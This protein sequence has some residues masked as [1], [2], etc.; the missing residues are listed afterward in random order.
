MPLL[1][2][3][4]IVVESRSDVVIGQYAARLTSITAHAGDVIISEIMADPVPSVALPEREYIEIYNR[5]IFSFSLNKWK[6]CSGDRCASFP[7]VS[8]RPGEYLILCSHTDTVK[9]SQYGRVVGF[10]SFP[11]LPGETGIVYL[12]DSLGSLIHGLEYSSEWY[13]DKLKESGGWALEIIDTSFPFFNDGNWEA[14]SSRTG[15]TPGAVNSASRY[16]PDLQFHGL[17]NVF[18]DDSVTLNILFSETVIDL[19]ESPDIISVG[20]SSIRT[21]ESSDPLLRNFIIRTNEPFQSGKIY[22][23]RIN[24]N[25]TDFAGNEINRGVFRF[26]IPERADRRDIVFNELLFNPFPD[27]P[28]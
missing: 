20:M 22:S 9:F 5:T 15:G 1:A 21:V 8:I 27:D 16:N 28:D 6:L 23:F 11:S 12:T 3:G 25:L 4:R 7:E 26:G 18:P 13:K 2:S 19:T 24:G 10:K 14:S 17:E